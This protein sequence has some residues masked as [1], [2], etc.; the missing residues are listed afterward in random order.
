MDTWYLHTE[1][2]D[3]GYDGVPLLRDV[4]IGVRRGEILTLIG[5][6][7]SGKSTILKSMIRQLRLLSGVVV[8]DGQ[9]MAAMKEG[10]IAK[11]MAIL[12]TERLR[13]E[14]MTGEDV[15]S[16]GRYPY[17][18]RLGILTKADRE[19]VREAIALVHGEEFA[20]RPFAQ[21][22][23]GQR[24]RLLLARAVCQEPE[25]I[26]LDEPTSFLD[27][28]HKLEL[29]E[30]L[31]R[32]VRE[33]N[34]AVVMSL[35]ELDL[36]QKISDRVVS[37]T[38]DGVDRCDTPENIFQSAYIEALYGMESGSYNALF[39][40]LEMA[41]VSGKPRVFVIGGAGN[42]IPVYR[43]LQ[44]R[45]VPFA[46]GVLSEND[47]DYWVARALAVETVSVPAFAP[48]DEEAVAKASAL[49]IKCDHV[50]CCLD[51]FG[52]LNQGNRPLRDEAQRQ[53]K[54]LP[55]DRLSELWTGGDR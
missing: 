14:L 41:R 3:V 2:M 36:A 45:G 15:V 55:L 8:L 7:G 47:V 5:P 18:G 26:V 23:D 9:T 30:I 40:S 43:A 38:K 35:H 28:K 13:A 48:L 33:R 11:K 42:G 53:G 6:N 10:E 34:V 29:L 25:V 32:L 51:T 46:A 52:E 27:V 39:G 19:K 12:M 22:S 20:N 49:I 17:T 44:R 4:E 50:I 21:L 24:Q 31:K 16:T 1:H 37:V 54:L